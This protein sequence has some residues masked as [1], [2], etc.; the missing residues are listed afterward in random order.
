ML[1]GELMLDSIT[2]PETLIEWHIRYS[3]LA[4]YGFSKVDLLG[5]K[6]ETLFQLVVVLSMLCF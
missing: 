6:L 2:G 5:L 3:S 4:Y 1:I